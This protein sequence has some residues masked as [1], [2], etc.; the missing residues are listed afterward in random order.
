MVRK[1]RPAFSSLAAYRA[2][3]STALRAVTLPDSRG[4]GFACPVDAAGGK[5][6]RQV[7][8]LFGCSLIELPDCTIEIAS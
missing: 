8:L 5:R 1:C 7:Y 4:G 6:R 2:A 3:S